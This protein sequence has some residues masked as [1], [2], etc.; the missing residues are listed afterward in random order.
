MVHLIRV[1]L[2]HP[3]ESNALQVNETPELYEALVSVTCKVIWGRGDYDL[4]TTGSFIRY[5]GKMRVLTCF[6]DQSWQ[7]AQITLKVGLQSFD[8]IKLA[9]NIGF[10]LAKERDLCVLKA[11]EK[12][13]FYFDIAGDFGSPKLGE[14]V[15]FAGYPFGKD[16][17]IIHE[18]RVSSLQDNSFTIDGTVVSG[19]SG[20]IVVAKRNGK[21]ELLGLISSQVVDMTEKLMRARAVDL[22]HYNIVPEGDLSETYGDSDVRTVVGEIIKNLISNTSTGIGKATR[23]SEFPKIFTVEGSIGKDDSLSK[24]TKALSIVKEGD[25]RKKKRELDF[26]QISPLNEVWD[27]GAMG[28]MADMMGGNDMWS[29]RG[30]HNSDPTKSLMPSRKGFGEGV[31]TLVRSH[32][33]S[34]EVSAHSDGLVSELPVMHRCQVEKELKSY[35]WYF[36]KNGGDHDIWTNGT[37]VGGKPFTE[38]VPRHPGIKE[39]LAK[40][41]IKTAK[42]NPAVKENTSE[43]ENKPT[44]LDIA[45]AELESVVEDAIPGLVKAR[46]GENG[47]KLTITTSG[48]SEVWRKDGCLPIT[49]SL[50]MNLDEAKGILKKAFSK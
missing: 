13:N 30:Q 19:N 49:I 22:K 31:S 45:I 12:T 41:I 25:Q 11:P 37:M 2:S 40:K 34:N 29:R 43:P 28:V 17:P 39:G 10:I 23:I 5:Q 18:G 50:Y 15:Y 6:H 1:D 44:A 35:G 4:G 46:L 47:Y 9:K 8:N 32:G 26:S 20:S 42:D 14:T 36:L 38:S 48:G 24:S 27:T 3:Q 7:A 16:N 21:L 33:F